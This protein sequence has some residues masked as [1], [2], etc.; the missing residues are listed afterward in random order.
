MRIPQPA[1]IA[2]AAL[3]PSTVAAAALAAATVTTTALAPAALAP[4]PAAQRTGDLLEYMHRQ[5]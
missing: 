4:F 5:P 3:A 1:T 2:T